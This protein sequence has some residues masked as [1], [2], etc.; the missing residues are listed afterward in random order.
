[1][2]MAVLNLP[3]F[4]SSDA[5]P[6]ERMHWVRVPFNAVMELY[7]HSVLR[8]QRNHER[9][10]LRAKHLSVLD[11]PTHY[12]FQ[13][14]RT[15]DGKLHLIDGYTRLTIMKEGSMPYPPYAWL[16]VVDVDTKAGLE[17]LYDTVDSKYAVKRGRDAYEEGLRRS[18]L[19]D[20]LQSTLFSGA[21]VVTAVLTAAGHNDVRQAVWDMRTGI[22]ALD[23]LHLTA[24]PRKL[25][26]GALAALLLIASRGGDVELLKRL[27]TILEDPEKVTPAERKALPAAVECAKT[28]QHRRDLG[29]LSGKNVVPLMAMVLGAW[30]SIERGS[31]SSRPISRADF[32][33]MEEA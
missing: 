29:S 12:N 28:L 33:A 7:N 9:R 31:A 5:R 21:Q 10:A 6:D 32:L 23:R 20:K 17:A 13:A 11:L 8:V 15:P 18:S 30:V 1:M 24:G 25:P 4:T 27:A 26:Q 14:G 3:E 2:L 16:G 22:R 19:L